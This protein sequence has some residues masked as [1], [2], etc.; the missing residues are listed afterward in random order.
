M[1]RGKLWEGGKKGSNGAEGTRERAR[2]WGS[3]R[4]RARARREAGCGG[5][6]GRGAGRGAG[7]AEDNKNAGAGHAPR[8]MG[9]FRN[10][11]KSF[12]KAG[13]LHAESGARA[14]RPSG[15][16]VQCDTTGCDMLAH[17][18]PPTIIQPFVPTLSVRCWRHG[19]H[20][21]LL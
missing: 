4:A 17:M 3:T 1:K 18:A 21:Q 2:A 7:H 5:Q 19:G 12:A 10:F 14:M 13:C 16:H 11:R 20:S 9:D 6:A 8:D 15:L